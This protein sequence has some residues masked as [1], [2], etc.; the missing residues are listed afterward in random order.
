M[1]KLNHACR[2]KSASGMKS[3]NE[4]SSP[5]VALKLRNRLGAAAWR[6][7]TSTRVEPCAGLPMLAKRRNPRSGGA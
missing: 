1:R 3:P 7:L 4:A 6:S 5:K 2:A